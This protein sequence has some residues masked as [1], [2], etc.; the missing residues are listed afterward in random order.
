MKL[1]AILLVAALG[2]LSVLGCG[3]SNSNVDPNSRCNIEACLESDT[4]RNVCIDEYNDCVNL[5]GDPE[6]CIVAAT[7][8]CTV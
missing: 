4:L 1:R 8:T 6:E 3:D 2:A 7:E 5:G